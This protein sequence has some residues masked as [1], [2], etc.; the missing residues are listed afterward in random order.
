MC[1]QQQIGNHRVPVSP[2]SVQGRRGALPLFRPDHDR[3]A[4]GPHPRGVRRVIRHRAGRDHRR[5]AAAV[6]VERVH[7]ADAADEA[8]EFREVHPETEVLVAAIDGDQP[9]AA[10]GGGAD[11]GA[12]VPLG[13]EPGPRLLG[14]PIGQ[15]PAADFEQA[16][17]ADDVGRGVPIG[18]PRAVERVVDHARAGSSHQV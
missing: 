9:D 13:G 4:D 6:E 1:V 11:H 17:A 7:Q 2:I 12:R 14:F 15:H 5:R 16:H 3:I 8:L 10:V 18:G